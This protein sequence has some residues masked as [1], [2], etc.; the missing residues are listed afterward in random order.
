MTALANTLL[1]RPLSSTAQFRADVIRGLG[2][3]AKRLHSRYFYDAT[4]DRIFQRIMEAPE[5]YLTRAEN[6]ILRDRTDE[7][8]RALAGDA[9]EFDLYEL[10]AG[11]GTKTMHLL[12]RALEQ[13]RDP[14]YRPIDISEHVLDELGTAL[15]SHLPQL[16][17]SPVVAEYFEALRELPN[18]SRRPKAVLFLGSSIGNLDRDDTVAL[19]TGVIESLGPRDRFLI[20]FDL[21]KHPDTILRAY[22]DEA[23]HTRDLNINLLHRINRE[24]GADFRPEKFIHAPVYDPAS[25]RAS[26]YI[27]STCDQV[28]HIPGAARPIRFRS[29]EAVH[30][31]ISQKYDRALIEDLAQAAGA[32]ITHI[33]TD[34]K[35]QF[36]DVVMAR[37]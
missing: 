35:E 21:K 25:G 26:S 14:V 5:Y 19:M 16:R 15:C 28:V 29:W 12:K 7:I 2:Q 20:G 11:D 23:G 8:L 6:E 3:E 30:T 31:E 1:E 34:A 37:S 17:F 22:N 18:A 32:R 9:D 36:A 13:D 27:V 33:F 10:G 4:G 24:L